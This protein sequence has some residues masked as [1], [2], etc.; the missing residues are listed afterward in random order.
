[1]SVHAEPNKTVEAADELDLIIAGRA[2]RAVFQPLIDLDSG[3]V[4]AYEAL[5]R[6]RRACGGHGPR[7]FVMSL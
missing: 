6:G 1:M 7:S 2:V 4:L 3:D 5:A